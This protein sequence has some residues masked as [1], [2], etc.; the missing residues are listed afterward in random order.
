MAPQSTSSEFPQCVSDVRW[1]PAIPLILSLTACL[2]V[3]DVAMPHVEVKIAGTTVSTGLGSY[4]WQSGGHGQCADMASAEA[5]IQARKLTPILVSAASPGAITFDRRPNSMDLMVGAMSR[6][7]NQSRSQV[8]PSRLRSHQVDG[9]TS[10][11]DAGTR[12][13][14]VGCL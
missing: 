4:C 5:V 2:G 3:G 1:S 9:S 13:M 12:E 10:C 11:R 7:F 8:T 6:T 14:S